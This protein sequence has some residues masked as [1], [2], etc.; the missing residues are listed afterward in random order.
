MIPTAKGDEQ[1]ESDPLLD[2][3]PQN[4]AGAS[5]QQTELRATW[6]WRFFRF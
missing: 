2:A 1:P 6:A 3:K 5:D 4:I